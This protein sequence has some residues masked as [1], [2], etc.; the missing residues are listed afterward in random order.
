M[1]IQKILDFFKN[2][3]V[4]SS[5]K[6]QKA[7][8]EVLYEVPQLSENEA[9]ANA[10]QVLHHVF[11]L[12]KIDILM[13]K[14]VMLLPVQTQASIHTPLPVSSQ[15]S[16]KENQ[17]QILED[18]LTRLLHSEPIQY[19][20]GEVY[21]QDLAFKVSPA[22]LIPR[23]ETEEIID[24]I[25]KKHQQT[26]P[27][28]ILDFGTGSGCMAV[29][30]AYYFP[31]SEVWALDISEEALALAK[32]NALQNQVN[33]HFQKADILQLNPSDFPEFSMIVSN[34]PYVTEAE[35]VKMQANVLE[36]EPSLAL[37]VPDDEPLI[38]YE[39]IIAFA[40]KKLSHQGSIYL[41]INELFGNEMT[42][43]LQKYSFEKVRIH[44]DMQG[45]DRF[46]SAIK[47]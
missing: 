18:M 37:F 35:K 28:K 19:I 12:S 13:D 42:Q 41:E 29:S 25:L 15:A 5:R 7:I 6:L 4:V 30:L 36:H 24:F 11:K 43:L 16:I 47:P 21:F 32:H 3:E 31:T 44:K 2:Q 9:K 45:K 17:L 1:S 34:P 14:P 8:E 33:V 39:A 38:F 22:V 26:P 20:I 27:Q 40:Q 10:F 46:V 23:P